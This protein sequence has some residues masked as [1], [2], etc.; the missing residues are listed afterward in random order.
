MTSIVDVIRG[1]RGQLFH[2]ITALIHGS[3]FFIRGAFIHGR[4][5]FMAVN[6]I[7]IIGIYH[8]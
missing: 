3:L 4:S 8:Y 5:L 6:G 1:V 2:N 7:S